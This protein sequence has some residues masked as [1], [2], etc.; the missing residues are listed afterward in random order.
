MKKIRSIFI[1]TLL[2]FF[3]NSFAQPFADIV[4]FNYQ[5]FNSNYETPVY[6]KNKTDNYV[7]NFFLP[8]EF[9]NGHTF[10]VRLNTETIHSTVFSDSSYSYRLSS[11]SL[12]VGIK[13]VTK[14]K[15][16]ETILM[17]IPK[18]TSDFRD[19]INL[20]DF[21]LGGIFLQQFI[22]NNKLKIKAGLYY[23]REAFGDFYIPLVGVDWKISDRINLYG[24]LPSNYKAE[25][26]IIKNK[27]YTG[28]NLKYLTRSFRLSHSKNDDYVRYDEAQLKLF[29]DC[30]VYKKLLVFCEIGYSIGK[31]PLQYTY[32][33]KE[34]NYFSNPIYSPTKAYPLINI[35]ITYRVRFDLVKR[36]ENIP[37]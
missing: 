29:I 36:E 27:L 12:P 20:Y 15:K 8:K 2:L 14:N 11:I 17:T 32:N 23:N 22:L 10:L 34:L 37:Q 3:K 24:I 35:G 28:I 33:T 19:R 30:F 26:A 16:W 7:L 21:Q 18:F 4:S 25:V 9:K 1:F 5:A 31:N 13:L 6:G